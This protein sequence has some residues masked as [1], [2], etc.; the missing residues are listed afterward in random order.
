MAPALAHQGKAS[1]FV[2]L[3]KVPS[4]CTCQHT[5]SCFIHSFTHSF[6]HSFMH[7]F[8][9]PFTHS[10]T[11]IF[12]GWGNYL[13]VPSFMFPQIVLLHPGPSGR[14]SLVNGFMVFTL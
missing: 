1:N 7:A 12:I 4:S 13:L 2:M 9:H 10:N 14:D 11:C 3:G 6:M 5:K 8:I